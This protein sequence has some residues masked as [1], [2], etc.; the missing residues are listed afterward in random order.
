MDVDRELIA[1]YEVDDENQSPWID[2]NIQAFAGD[3]AAVDKED[4]EFI[5]SN[6]MHSINGFV[7]GNLPGYTM[8]VGE[9]VRWYLM[10]MGTEVDLH[11]PHWHG[12]TVT[13]MGMRTD[14]VSLL[15]ATMI[16]AD[17]QPD[18]AG[19]WA[20]HCHVGDHI[21]AGMLSLYDVSP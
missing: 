9:H 20:F 19:T 3:P 7:Y 1:N 2:E 11:T 16:V 6:L 12:N 4:D 13:V 5:E 21:A 17:M 15:P 10:A 18:D 8:K 14:V